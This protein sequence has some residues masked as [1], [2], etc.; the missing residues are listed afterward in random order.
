MT[1]LEAD[2]LERVINDQ[3]NS[4][5]KTVY[6]IDRDVNEAAT[7]LQIVAKAKQR[8]ILTL[9]HIKAGNNLEVK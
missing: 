8:I 4:I 3:F 2:W 6:S 1:R 5:E 7:F 9:N